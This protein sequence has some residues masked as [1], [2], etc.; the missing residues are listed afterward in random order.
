ME[1]S[2]TSAAATHTIESQQSDSASTRRLR[3][4]GWWVVGDVVCEVCECVVMHS[5]CNEVGIRLTVPPPDGAQWPH[6]VKRVN[7]GHRGDAVAALH[8]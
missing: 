1:P 4:H 8:H 6:D 5:T 2:L 7:V 3:L